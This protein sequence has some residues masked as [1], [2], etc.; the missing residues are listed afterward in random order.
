MSRV[1]SFYVNNN[2]I[3]IKASENLGINRFIMLENKLEKSDIS[4][5]GLMSDMFESLIGSLYYENGLKKNEKNKQYDVKGEIIKNN[6]IKV[7]DHVK[8]ENIDPIKNQLQNFTLQKIRILPRYFLI[9]KY[10]TQFISACFLNDFMVSVGEGKTIKESENDCATKSMKI[11][12]KRKNVKNLE[13]IK[14]IL[15]EN[16]K[17]L[18]INDLIH[19]ETIE[20]INYD[21][22]V[23]LK[24]LNSLI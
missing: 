10:Q 11:F 13:E 8:I 16:K 3:L 2:E 1:K 17:D 4:Y 20:V 6:I 24:R 18:L 15:K 14:S 7:L 5:N 22:Y 19:L 21:I 12:N 23:L 9:A